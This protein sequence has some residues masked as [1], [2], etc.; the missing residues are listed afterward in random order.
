MVKPADFRLLT[1]EESLSDYRFRPESVNRHRFCKQCGVR[2]GTVGFVEE[3]GGDFFTVSIP[4]LDELS[5]AE[6]A[7]LPVQYCDGRANNWFAEPAVSSHL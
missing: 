3:I 4:T 1:S 5:D 2:I 7:A 6:L